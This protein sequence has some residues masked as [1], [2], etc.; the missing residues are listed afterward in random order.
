MAKKIAKKRKKRQTKAL[1][2]SYDVAVT[3]AESKSKREL[4]RDG[5]GHADASRKPKVKV[6]RD[7]F[8][9]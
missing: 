3:D 5:Q 4:L 9:R 1:E 2:D 7:A 6:K 8:E